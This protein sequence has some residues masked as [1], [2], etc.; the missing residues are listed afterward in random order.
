M[1]RT[2]DVTISGFDLSAL[3]SELAAAQAE[4]EELK[5]K[6]AEAV[7]TLEEVWFYMK[8]GKCRDKIKQLKVDLKGQ[9]DES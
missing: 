8:S 7:E 5:R 9:N 6:V 3:E 2:H 4:N 1:G